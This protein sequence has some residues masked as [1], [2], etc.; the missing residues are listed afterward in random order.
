MSGAPPPF[1][2]LTRRSNRLNAATHI[3]TGER[4]VVAR[5]N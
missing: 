2:L 5:L 1:H 4:V 3:L